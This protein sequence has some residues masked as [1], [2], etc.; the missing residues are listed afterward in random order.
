V[1]PTVLTNLTPDERRSFFPAFVAVPVEVHYRGNY[2]PATFETLCEPVG[3]VVL[4]SDGALLA[5][6]A[7]VRISH[8]T[9][10]ALERRAVQLG[11]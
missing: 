8:R 3:A 10:H 1:N 5:P 2:V 6:L 11:T 9:L 4:L 7:D